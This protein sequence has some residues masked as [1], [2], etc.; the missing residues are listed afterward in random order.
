MVIFLFSLKM[1]YSTYRD[2]TDAPRI[3]LEEI[4]P[5]ESRKKTYICCTIL[6]ETL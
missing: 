1:K 3:K 5:M 6:T 2:R 4:V